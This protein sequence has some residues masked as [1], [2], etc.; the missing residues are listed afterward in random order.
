MQANQISF[1]RM[2]STSGVIEHY[3]VPK[4]QREYTWGK[5]EWTQLLQD[6]EENDRQYF[7]GSLICIKQESGG[8]LPTIYDLVD[9][10]QRLTTLSILLAAWYEN[11]KALDLDDD[12]EDALVNRSQVKRMLIQTTE[13]T[14]DHRVP[15]H[16]NERLYLRIRPSTQGGNLDDYTYLLQR[17]GILKGIEKQKFWGNR[18]IGLCFNHFKRNLP[19]S[20]EELEHIKDKVESLNF[21]HITADSQADAFVLFESLN[22]RGVP[23]SIMDII[24]NKMLAEL[25]ESGQLNID[26]AFEKWKK[27]L[28]SLPDYGVQE[29]FLRHYYNAYRDERDLEIDNAP[30]AMRSNLVK[31]YEKLIENKD[32][33]TLLN[34]LIN[35]S[36]IYSS[37]IYPE[38][39]HDEDIKRYLKELSYL[40]AAPAFAFILYFE[41][42]ELFDK[43]EKIKILR[44][45]SNYFFRRSLTD[46]PPT[47]SL[48]KIFLELINEKHDFDFNT[49]EAHLTAND[50][51]PVSSVSMVKELLN[52]KIYATNKDATRFAL[53]KIETA[54]NDPKTVPNLWKRDGSR[55][56]IW[57]VEH[58][59]PQ[60]EKMR[61]E[62]ID[63]L[64]SG[65]V[66]KAR[67]IQEEVLHLLGN[68]TLTPYNSKLMDKPFKDKQTLQATNINGNSYE[69]GLKNNLALNHSVTF[70]SGGDITNLSEA[71]KW[72]KKEVENRTDVMINTLIDQIKFSWE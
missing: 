49:V 40:G 18:R 42:L 30:R 29:R 3:H 55:R 24:K 22:N 72:S 68:L 48:D 4:Y 54:L 6:I 47:R 70:Q 9:G 57:T 53:Y 60:N 23:L 38:S 33:E 59:L 15:L 2:F 27:I 28:E 34:D 67:R 1:S 52:G 69:A 12:D 58:I 71:D 19:E 16:R 43:S 65:D 56:L 26:E 35:S 61:E 20:R 37:V 50:E 7:M 39:Y 64:A 11:Y 41:E 45:L 31:I 25:E 46:K 44:L 13:D 21:I 17:A 32:T 36:S 5:S 14:N 66:Q 63:M 8:G 51:F 62:W 10:Q